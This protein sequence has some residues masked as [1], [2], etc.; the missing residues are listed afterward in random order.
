MGSTIATDGRIST[1]T[2]DDRVSTI[3]A[4]DDR[5]TLEF[6]SIEV[7]D[8]LK[9]LADFTGLNIVTTDAVTGTITLQLH[10]VPWE[11]ALA[12][13][14]TMK[15][16]SQ[17]RIG[18]VIMV[19]ASDEIASGEQLALQLSQQA[20]DLA[21]LRTE[22]IQIHYAKAADIAGLLKS[23]NNTLLSNRG[24]VSVDDRTNILLIQDFGEKLAEIQCLVQHLDVPVRQV[25]IESRIV[26]ANDDFEKELGINLHASVIRGGSDN[27]LKI[28]LLPTRLHSGADDLAQWGFSGAKL[29]GGAIL[30]LELLALEHEGLGKIIASPRLI[31]S[32]QQQAYIEAG[33]EI[34]YQESTSSGGASIAFKKAVLRLDVTP[35]ITPDN[36]IILDLKVNQDSRGQVTSGVPSIHT[37]ELHT[38]VLVADGE[39]VVLGGI[40]QQN[41]MQNKT[42]V[43]LLGRLPLIGWLFRSKTT[44]H[45]RNELLIFVTPNIIQ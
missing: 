12:S 28:H 19:G 43:P 38:K 42:R 33:E 40:Y 41:K 25:L 22:Y 37:R 44:S 2:A 16:L 26:F 3:A 23:E 31:T 18:D 20:G 5:I 11:E 8:V 15:K 14:L 24:M 21:P 39:T 35:Q 1:I 32:N 17:R 13:I 30:D 9:I 29:P 10:Q 45:Q 6:Q 4:D 34:P 27:N 36:H 7:K